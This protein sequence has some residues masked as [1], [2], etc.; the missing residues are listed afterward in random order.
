MMDKLGGRK[1]RRAVLTC[2]WYKYAGAHDLRRAFGT[3]WSK[4]VMPA[5]LKQLMRHRS[6]ETTMKYYVERNADLQQWAS[7]VSGSVAAETKTAATSAAESSE[8]KSLTS[9]DV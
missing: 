9:N 1:R 4:R 8:R 2:D 7:S 6:V 3:G 5:V